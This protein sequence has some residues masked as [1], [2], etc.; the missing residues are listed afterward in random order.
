MEVSHVCRSFIEQASARR[1]PDAVVTFNGLDMY[2]MLRAAKALD[3]AD[4]ADF[5]TAFAPLWNSVN[6]PRIEYALE[7]VQSRRLQTPPPDLPADQVQVATRFVA[8]PTSIL[9]EQIPLGRIHG[10]NSGIRA[11][12]NALMQ[13]LFGLPRSSFSNHCQDP[14]NA[15]FVR[16]LT[17]GPVAVGPLR[18]RGLTAAVDSL[19]SILATVQTSQRL[20][21]RALGTQGMLCARFVRG[22]TTLISNHSW[23]S[24]I[25]L[26]ID[27][28]TDTRGDKKVLFGAHLLA[29]IFNAQGWFWGAG[30]TTEDAMHFEG[31]SDLVTRWAS[32]R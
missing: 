10:F 25:D 18:V 5:R 23:G 11:A 24:A 4:I 26:T 22:S 27:G 29:P 19:R 16:R 8:L 7:T 12:D 3:A 15:S 20:V 2:E 30:F 32:V 28:V 17:A 21:Y 6:G 13:R 9:V 1:W 31:G 14:D